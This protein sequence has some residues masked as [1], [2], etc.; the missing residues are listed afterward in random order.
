MKGLWG[1]L[2]CLLLFSS[3]LEGS[4]P[5]G[6]ADPSDDQ[7]LGIGSDWRVLNQPAALSIRDVLDLWRQDVE[8]H[9][10]TW[11]FNTVRLAFAFP[12]SGGTTRNVLQLDELDQVLTLLASYG[13]RG[14]LDLH[15]LE[16]M[17]GYFG[18]AA[19]IAAWVDLATRYRDD[20]RIAAFELFNEPFGPDK[21]SRVSTWDPSI[22]GGG[23]NLSD[24]TEGV[25]AAL[26][27]CVDAIRSTGDTHPIV[28]PDPWWFRPTRDEVYD[29]HSFIESGYSREN[30]VITMHP[31]YL[32][33]DQSLEKMYKDFLFNQLDKFEAWAEHY[34]LWL[35]EFGA[36]SP[37]EKPWHTQKT[38]GVELVNYALSKGI[39]FNL[40]IARE[41][42]G[43][44]EE[45]WSLVEDILEASTFSAYHVS[46]KVEHL[47][48]DYRELQALSTQLLLDYGALQSSYDQLL[49]DYSE[50]DSSYHQVVMRYDFLVYALIA[51]A[52][53]TVVVSVF[54][55]TRVSKARTH[56][57]PT[58]T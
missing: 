51:I 29:P 39:G 2:L 11:R 20:D 54:L 47:R 33:T 17:P 27:A 8:T 34:P 23:S 28:Y 32:W 42:S 37:D 44:R 58:S 14:I 48:V 40:W 26:A 16:D 18:S 55:A 9:L 45:T 31:W 21:P 46:T 4:V 19:W 10:Q 49:L 57:I 13:I 30:I 53:V 6:H 22:T 36:A 1:A 38:V 3:Y 52:I 25:A 56:Q 12:G 24:G 35:G 15:N 7:W 50:L 41:S 5:R 43:Q